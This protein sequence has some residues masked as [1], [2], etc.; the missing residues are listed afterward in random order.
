MGLTHDI[1][2]CSAAFQKRLHG[3]PKVDHATAG[4]IECARINCGF[5]ACAVIG[6]HS[7]LLDYGNA[8]TD[9]P[10]DSTFCGR[11]KK[12]LAGGIPPYDCNV[13]FAVPVPPVPASEDFLFL[14]FW[15]RMLYSCLVDADYL[16][17]ERFMENTVLKEDAYDSL[18]VLLERLEAYIEPWWTP[19]NDLNRKRCRILRECMDKGSLKKG[20]YTLTVPT[21]G[22]KTVASLAFALKHA[23]AHGMKR[24][25]YVIPYTSII[26]QNAAVFKKILGEKNV[27]EHH[28]NMSFSGDSEQPDAV[29]QRVRA[30]ENWDA[31]VIVTTAVQFFES[32]YANR[33]SKCRKLHNIANSVIIFDEA[34]MIPTEHLNP[35]VAAISN[36]VS[37]FEAT[38]VLCTATQPALADLFRK[39]SPDLEINELCSQT[40]DLYDRFRRVTFNKIGKQ[41]TQSLADLLGNS[42]QVLC[43]VNSRKSAQEIFSV[44]PEEGRFHLS[45]L[46]YPAHRQQVLADIKKRLNEGL[47]CRV[48]STSLIEAGVDID[49]PAVY[50]EM[51]GLDSIL[52]AAGRCNREGRRDASHSIVT[53]FESESPPPPLF[54]VNIGA[55]TQALH[56]NS[57]P[58]DIETINRYFSSLRSF[59]GDNIDKNHIVSSMSK[60]IS[61][62]VLPFETVANSFKLIDDTCKCVYIPINEGAELVSRI[63]EGTASR[64]VYRAAGRYSVSVYEQHYQALLSAGAISILDDDSAVLTDMSLYSQET[65]LSLNMDSGK[66]LFI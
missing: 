58:A 3:G 27:L 36:L 9:Q 54:R 29:S 32:M 35:C 38:A 41:S 15:T 56:E 4:A 37:H 48:V 65:G 19:T 16:D 7:G 18:S 1:G 52:Q 22:G 46:M 13:K 47:S 63:A 5:D 57:D 61:G 11:I 40:R 62:C 12:G 44:L 49:F 20:L 23:V 34:Q 24:I 14:S 10:G 51:A 30:T 64:S 42:R 17:T 21:G 8:V 31:P 45:T 66:A 6:H 25:I 60:G 33:S 59:I 55:C 26:E 28:S 53:I 50:R 2:K 43:I 39:F